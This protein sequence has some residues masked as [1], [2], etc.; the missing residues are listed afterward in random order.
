MGEDAETHI[1]TLGGAWGKP[2]GY[3]EK[4]IEARG[5]KNTTKLQWHTEST[6]QG[7]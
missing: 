4:T 2:K 7:S 3:G 1:Q 6:K 5:V